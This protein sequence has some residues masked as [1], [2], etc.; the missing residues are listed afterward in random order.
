MRETIISDASCFIILSNIAELD[1]LRVTYGTVVTTTAIA[2]EFGE[3]LPDWVLIRDPIPGTRHPLTSKLGK[4]EASAIT[5]ALEIPGSTVVLDDLRARRAAEHLD[6]AVTG[7][8]GVIVRAKKNGH[9]VSVK[10]I[11]RKMR[12]TNFR[13]SASIEKNALVQADEL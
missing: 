11:L 1:I 13:F 6:I 5:L 8:V 9:I 12:K 10:P 3:T 2:D 7:T 4:G